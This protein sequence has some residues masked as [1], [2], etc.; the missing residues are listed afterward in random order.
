[1]QSLT[2]RVNLEKWQWR[3][4]P[5]SLKIHAWSFTIRLFNFTAR[6]DVWGYLHLCRD[7]VVI[8]YIWLGWYYFEFCEIIYIYIYTYLYYPNSS[9]LSNWKLSKLLCWVKRL[10]Q[11]LVSASVGNIG[12]SQV[13]PLRARVDLRVMAIKW[14]TPF[15]KLQYYLNLTHSVLLLSFLSGTLVRGV[16]ALCRDTVGVFYSLNRLGQTL[17]GTITPAQRGSRSDGSPRQLSHADHMSLDQNISS[18]G[19]IYAKFCNIVVI[20]LLPCPM[21]YSGSDCNLL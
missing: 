13:I 20:A 2:V 9:K 1:M 10:F 7:A 11:C 21:L 12:P 6:T 17:S 8:S 14:Y 4:T 18:V 15:P 19:N 3:S 5:H 16:L